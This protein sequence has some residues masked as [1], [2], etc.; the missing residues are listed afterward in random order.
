MSFEMAS[1]NLVVE[2]SIVLTIL[3]G[4]RFTLAEFAGA[5]IM[6]AIL[7]LLFRAFLP[8]RLVRDARAQA[9]ARPTPC[10]APVTSAVL[11][12]RSMAK[13]IACLSRRHR[14]SDRDGRHSERTG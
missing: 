2:L 1:T 6:V 10:P 14:R 9:I 3:M 13:L 7:V 11:P 5:P 4:W 12:P 8:R